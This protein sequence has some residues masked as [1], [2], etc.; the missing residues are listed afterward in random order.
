[1]FLLLFTPRFR[2]DYRHLSKRD[3][4]LEA[5]ID[6]ILALLAENPR[7]PRLKSHKVTDRSGEPAFSSEVTGDVRIIWLYG[8]EPNT[9]VLL[10][11]GGH[12]GSKKVYR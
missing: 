5:R 9:L 11:I 2:R 8:E 12:S 10:D 1:M 3:H 6:E 4:A 7:D